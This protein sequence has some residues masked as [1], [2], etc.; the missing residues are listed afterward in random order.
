MK[1][2]VSKNLIQEL[3]AEKRKHLALGHYQKAF[4]VQKRLDFYYYGRIDAK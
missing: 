1:N 2:P 4:E 3:E